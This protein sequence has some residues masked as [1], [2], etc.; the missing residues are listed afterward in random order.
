MQTHLRKSSAGVRNPDSRDAYIAKTVLLARPGWSK[1]LVSRLLGEPDRYKK[2]RGRSVE[3]FLYSLERVTQVESSP[4]FLSVQEA[5][6]K[7]KTA[8]AKAAA[9]KTT[10]LL[11]AI[12]A[13]PLSVKALPLSTARSLA[14]DHYNN[15]GRG[16]H[17]A[18]LSDEPVFL[19]RITVNFI[20]HELTQYDETLM[21]AAGKTGV[22]QAVFAVRKRIYSAI[23]IAY[24]NL[25]WE[26]ES[27]LRQRNLEL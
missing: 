22:Q 4:A 16:N 18:S 19:D 27:Q 17:F 15:R 6:A 20:R 25:A 12:A 9:T 21:E 7:R 8:A 13:M 26:C 14:V 3:M 1:T 11:K 2:V 23:A 24:P 5:L 10:K